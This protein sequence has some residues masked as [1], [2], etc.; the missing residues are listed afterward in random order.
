MSDFGMLTHGASFSHG[1]FYL[2][3]YKNAFEGNTNDAYYAYPFTSIFFA[4]PLHCIPHW[5]SSY[6]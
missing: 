5:R 1:V 4:D 3:K 2:S 6:L